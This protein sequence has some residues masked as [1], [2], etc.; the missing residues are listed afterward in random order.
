MKFGLAFANVAFFGQPDH[1]THL[2]QTAERIALT[3][4]GPRRS[5]GHCSRCRSI[6]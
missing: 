1:L 2:A 4:G 5:A 6:P 3:P